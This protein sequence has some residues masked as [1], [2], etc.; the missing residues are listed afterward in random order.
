MQIVWQPSFK[1]RLVGLRPVAHSL[2]SDFSHQSLMIIPDLETQRLKSEV[3]VQSY[4][5]ISTELSMIAKQ[6]SERS[7]LL[8]EIGALLVN[9]SDATLV[10]HFN[11]CREDVESSELSTLAS[12]YHQTPQNIEQWAANV[13]INS[14]VAD[15]P[16]VDFAE[17]EDGN[18]YLLVA[19]KIGDQTKDASHS[20]VAM[21]ESSVEDSVFS[22]AV[23]QLAANCIAQWDSWGQKRLE[24]VALQLA[25]IAELKSKAEQA[26]T[27]RE[28]SQ[29]V[30]NEIHK[31]LRPTLG[32]NTKVYLAITDRAE[33]IKLNAISGEEAF[34]DQ[35]DE[36]KRIEGA[37]REGLSR[38]GQ[39]NW[40]PHP[41][42]IHALLCHQ[43]V[44]E[45]LRVSYVE[46]KALFG[47]DGKLQ[48]VLM[49][50]GDGQPSEH[51]HSFIN[52]CVLGLASTIRLL[53]LGQPNKLQ[54]LLR[55][56]R[57]SFEDNKTVT[58]L[59]I[60]AGLLLLLLVPLPYQ[61][62]SKCEVHPLHKNFVSA[63]FAGQL[64][65][66][67]VSPGEIVS[68]GQLLAKIDHREIE[69]EL[70][71]IEAELH[72][73]SKVRDG[74]IA[75]HDSG[76]ARV[77]EFNVQRLTA[78][79]D[80]LLHRSNHHE[81]RSPIAGVILT[82]D[83]KYSQGKKLD[84]GQPLFEIAPLNELVV[85][86]SIPEDD[87]RFVRTGLETRL[88][89]DAFPLQ[90]WA[91]EIKTIHPVSEIRNNE[92]IFVATVHVDN[93]HGKLRP[94]MVGSASTKTSWSPVGWNLFHRPLSRV[95]RWIGW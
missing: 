16:K 57:K 64:E 55:K 11:W 71:E 62:G 78:R 51:S 75:A 29:V 73:A 93:E 92:N 30:V 33:Q 38:G 46:S 68:E 23:I 48:G 24:Q 58:A 50:C 59:K 7:E 28:A 76:H 79:R 18:H 8:Q 54:K 84:T 56:L 37:M 13:A 86:L 60:V 70:A 81:I 20:L 10:F 67:F 87:M 15:E 91:G 22:L 66:C 42:N 65:S 77:A 35:S 26:E 89:L 94:G 88:K 49:L 14:C 4:G 41:N 80:L 47:Q 25:S 40:P 1:Q 95:F 32:E 61:V 9:S 27:V 53:K 72:R 31:H 12:R 83:F 3:D 39:A 69:F 82:G 85:E 43:Q 17:A 52:G 2:T 63:P 44:V 21:F 34:D 90:S 45:H 5:R 36:A 6:A 19:S 74:Y